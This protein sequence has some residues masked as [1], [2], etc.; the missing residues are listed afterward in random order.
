MSDTT[1]DPHHTSAN[2]PFAGKRWGDD[3]SEERQRELDT[4][5]AAWDAAP[6][7]GER[8]GPL[9]RHIWTTKIPIS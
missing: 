3:I 6:N 2:D 5:L 1:T 7:H 4:M 9:I 8:K